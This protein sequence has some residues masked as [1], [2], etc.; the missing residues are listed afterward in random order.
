MFEWNDQQRMMRDMMRHWL[1]ANLEPVTQDMEEEKILP[2]EVARKFFADFN[3][4]DMMRGT[5]AKIIQKKKD[6]KPL[7][8]Q[9]SDDEV[10]VDVTRAPSASAIGSW[11][12][13]RV[14]P[15]F[16]LSFGASLGLCGATILSKGTPEQI[17]QWGLPVMTFDKI[18]CWGVTEPGSGS[19]AFAMKT[20][21]RRDGNHY[22][23]NGS[24]IFITNAP[25]AD[26]F[27]LYAR[28]DD[29]DASKGDK[30]NIHPFVL[31]KNTPG[32]SVSKPMK[33]MGMK[34][35]PTGEVFLNDVRIHKDQ[36][37]GGEP[38]GGRDQ[39][40]DVFAGERTGSGP[41]SGGI[42][43]RCLDECIKYS[44]E[45]KQFGRPIASFQLVQDKIARMY[46]EYNNVR[47]IVLQQIWQAKN[48]KA[49]WKDACAAKL[50]CTEA[51]VRVGLE[52]I[53]LLGGY[54]YIADFPVERLM[55]DAKLLTIGGGTSEI[56]ALNLAKA[57]YREHDFAVS[58]AGD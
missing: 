38:G 5:V 32:L 26:V 34:S 15:G 13:S 39:V 25:Y 10:E 29:G 47:N 45:R 11:E 53:Q 52:A 58:L 6:G 48:G 33:K 50:Y 36:L 14:N 44:M 31:A 18:G 22:V 8:A 20:I 17:E 16:C 35:S 21:A 41:M 55:R 28:I 37:L 2:F 42:I 3:M 9:Q 51:A 49:T 24:K 19:D 30:R 57:V 23:L 1:K 56:Q 40:K 43:E 46:I 12:M 27:V 54:G 7:A 4:A